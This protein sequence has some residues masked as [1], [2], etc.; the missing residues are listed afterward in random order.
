[1]RV[2]LETLFAMPLCLVLIVVLVAAGTDL[3]NFQIANALT[4]PLFLSGLMYQMVVGQVAGL[5]D[6]LLGT[7]VGVLPFLVVYA[8]GG[9]GAGDLKL[10]AGVG[11][12]MGP[13]FMLH[14][15]IVS[16]LLTG[17]YS[18]GLIIWNQ[19]RMATGT[20]EPLTHG[21]VSPVF[22]TSEN[23]KDVVAVVRQP[24]RRSK[25]IPFGAMV[26][27]GVIITAPWIG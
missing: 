9:M 25:A 15:V 5:A 4:V 12:W 2:N 17:L 26:A 24:D 11:C 8:K 23:S 22:D 16:G 18:M 20:I 7:L 19:A 14:V 13:W 27:L 3:W 21:H 6:S 1:M 10:M